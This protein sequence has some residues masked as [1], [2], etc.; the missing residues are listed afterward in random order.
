MN[1][2]LAPGIVLPSFNEDAECAVHSLKGRHL[3]G[4]I[5]SYQQ[6]DGAGNQKPLLTQ[7][8]KPQSPPS[9]PATG[10]PN[11]TVVP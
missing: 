5:R 3:S 8:H 7:L 10:Y 9:I 1:G 2:E 4:H 6:I 11:W